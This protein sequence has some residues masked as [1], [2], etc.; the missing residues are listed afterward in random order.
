MATGRFIETLSSELDVDSETIAQ[1]LFGAYEVGLRLGD[2]LTGAPVPKRDF[3]ATVDSYLPIRIIGGACRPKQAVIAAIRIFLIYLT[4]VVALSTSE[5][6]LARILSIEQ[7]VN[8]PARTQAVLSALWAPTTG[9]LYESLPLVRDGLSA[10][11]GGASA[12]EALI[13]VQRFV[14]LKLQW[15]NLLNVMIPLL[16]ELCDSIDR[17]DPGWG[18][19][20]KA[21]FKPEFST[22]RLYYFF[23][24]M[25]SGLVSSGSVFARAAQALN[26]RM[27]RRTSKKTL[28]DLQARWEALKREAEQAGY[29]ARQ[30]TRLSGG[31]MMRS[32]VLEA[33][34][35]I[36]AR[37]AEVL[38]T[39]SV[40]TAVKSM[41]VG[42]VVVLVCLYVVYKTQCS[43]SNDALCLELAKTV[44]LGPQIAGLL[45]EVPKAY[46]EYS[47]GH[48]LLFFRA[49]NDAVKPTA[50]KPLRTSDGYVAFVGTTL[51]S[52]FGHIFN[53]KKQAAIASLYSGQALQS[54]CI[55]FSNISLVGLGTYKAISGLIQVATGLVKAQADVRRTKADLVDIEKAIE[56]AKQLPLFTPT[57][58]AMVSSSPTRASIIRPVGFPVRPSAIALRPAPR[59]PSSPSRSRPISS[60]RAY[61]RSQGYTDNTI[62]ML[63]SPTERRTIYEANRPR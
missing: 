13:L 48:A 2:P 35:P 31:Q 5:Y 39:K 20:M 14:T 6:A 28:E 27:P 58:Q 49:L 63:F 60:P 46:L 15:E 23:A 33:L 24:V 16:N 7:P 54:A 45:A 43:G 42:L 62:T 53:G 41:T 32:D 50:V 30:V 55:T 25:S 61:L 26:T 47:Y 3:D 1:A 29:T 40:A 57:V 59:R 4:V 9:V 36:L 12:A 56:A 11:I 34:R 18:P 51:G 19:F 37:V 17:P 21:V 8:V 52:V 38:Q 22:R 44:E 10:L